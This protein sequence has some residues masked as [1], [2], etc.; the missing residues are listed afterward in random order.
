[1]AIDHAGIL[2]AEEAGT[3]D[4][5]R[6]ACLVAKSF[7]EG[8]VCEVGMGNLEGD[9]QAFDRIESAIDVRVRTIREEGFDPVLSEPGARA[10]STGLNRGRRQERRH[11][12]AR[13]CRRAVGL[14]TP[15][16]NEKW[17]LL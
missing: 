2:E 11:E 10:K 12:A 17:N 6:E 5:G 4:L 1:V 7:Q 9:T 3:L 15:L 14:Q 8:F 16:R 13:G